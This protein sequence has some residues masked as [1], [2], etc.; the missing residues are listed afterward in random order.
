MKLAKREKLFIGGAAGF[1]GI[2]VI[3]QLIVFPYFDE[4]SR[5]KK[6]IQS[7]IKYSELLDEVGS[8]GQSD[9]FSAGRDRI[10]SERSP[11]FSLMSFA[12]ESAI[13]AGIQP[14]NMK[15]SKGREK[16]G[17]VEDMIEV[18][19]D[20]ISSSQLYDFLY[21]VEK[22]EEYIFIKRINAKKIKNQEGYLDATIRILTYQK[23][24]S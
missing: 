13:A 11:S 10:L 24:E 17:Y 3:M 16:D 15:P 22:P 21:R 8:R 20:G 6:E 1:I 7:F 12:N 19:I 9:S 5:M 14:K 23:Q 18:S 2:L 4:K